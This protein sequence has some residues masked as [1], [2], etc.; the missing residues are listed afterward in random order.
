MHRLLDVA[1]Q[2][3]GKAGDSFV[4]QDRVLVALAE[5]ETPAGRALRAHGA[6]M[7]A[8]ERA[9][10]EVRKGRVVDSANAEANFDALKKYARD[11]TQLARDGKLDPVIGA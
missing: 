1:Q 3:A 2:K 5:S 11:V 4:A 7:G 9:V 8:L 10:A 6:T